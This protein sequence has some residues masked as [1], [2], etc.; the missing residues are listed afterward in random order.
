MTAQKPGT[1][2]T[3]GSITYELTRKSEHPL[4]FLVG[5]AVLH[6]SRGF[7]PNAYPFLC[8]LNPCLVRRN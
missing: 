6:L 3:V 8:L 4:A 2:R 1:R 7:L 5:I